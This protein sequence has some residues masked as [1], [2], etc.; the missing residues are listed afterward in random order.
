MGC[1]GHVERMG[2]WAINTN[3]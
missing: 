2:R 3:F 1:S